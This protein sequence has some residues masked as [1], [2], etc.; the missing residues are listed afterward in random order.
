MLKIVGSYGPRKQL[1]K[2]SSEENFPRSLRVI[3]KVVVAARGLL[4]TIKRWNGFKVEGAGGYCYNTV[5]AL[6]N[7]LNEYSEKN[8]C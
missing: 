6:R 1:N 8:A 3:S 5:K 7:G 4:F 2:F